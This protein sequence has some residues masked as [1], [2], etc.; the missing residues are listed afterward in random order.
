MPR[1]AIVFAFL[2]AAG[3]AAAGT[4]HAVNV[5]GNSATQGTPIRISD[6]HPVNASNGT[7]FFTG[8]AFSFP[9]HV[10][11]YDRVDMTWSSGLSGGSGAEVRATLLADD[12]L[13]TGPAGPVT[14]TLHFRVRASFARLGGFDGNGAHG[15][16]LDVQAI[17]NNI[18][19]LGT[20]AV[21]NAGTTTANGIFSGHSGDLVDIPF[22]VSGSF[23]VGS[24]FVVELRLL[25]NGGT[26]GNVFNTNPGYYETN[27][28]AAGGPGG[29]QLDEAGGVVMDLPAGYTLDAPS[30]GL[31]DNHFTSVVG[32]PSSVS[33]DALTVTPN[34]ASGV[35]RFT[36][37]LGKAGRVRAAIFD[38]AGRRARTILDGPL[39]AGS[40]SLSWDGRRDDGLAVAP[41]VYFARVVTLERTMLRRI[42]RV[43]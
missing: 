9:G 28:G 26:Y 34:P 18:W 37:S 32:V 22:T 36:F 20:Y 41:G 33:E 6:A 12:F 19:A 10:G 25:E 14:G 7:A 21:N 43:D 15:S 29:L 23:P 38:V 11:L 39:P 3:P 31:V 4:T 2:L 5:F 35:A 30:M 24:P 8:A 16:R 27:A 17:A 42:V 1:F 13:I 40:Q